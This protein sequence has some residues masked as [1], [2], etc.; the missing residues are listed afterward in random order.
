MNLAGS[1]QGQPVLDRA[2]SSKPGKLFAAKFAELVFLING[3]LERA[4]DFYEDFKAQMTE[5]GR[6]RDG[7]H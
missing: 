6:E 2:G 4:G 5:F 7:G 1:P 3:T